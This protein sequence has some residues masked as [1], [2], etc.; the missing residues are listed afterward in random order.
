MANLK[1]QLLTRDRGKT[2]VVAPSRTMGRRAA[3]RQ[4]GLSHLSPGLI[5]T[6]MGRDAL[7]LASSYLNLGGEDCVLLPAYT[8][9]DVLKQFV[10]TATVLFYDVGPDLTISPDQILAHLLGRKVRMMLMINYFGFLQPYRRE[11]KDICA[12][13]GV[14][15][16]EDCAHS[17]LTEGSGETGDLAIYSFRKILP[18]PDGG[19]LKV[20][21]QGKEP[22]PRYYPRF[23]SDLLSVLATAKS[24]LHI[25]TATLSR[26]RVSAGADRVNVFRNT[27]SAVVE[28]KGRI[29][30][31]SFSTRVRLAH[32]PYVEVIR[33][34]RADFQFWRDIS[35]STPSIRPIFEDIPPGVCPL[36]FPVK[37]KDRVPLEQRAQSAG[38]KLAVHWR[39]NPE[40]APHC[41]TSH[42]LSAHML[43]LPLYPAIT[44]KERERLAPIV[45]GSA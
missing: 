44:E 30:P 34:R 38:I 17:L 9:Q 41:V 14:F 43:T 39:L 25:R 27:S 23:Y 22:A 37:I 26:A 3:A 1:P 19:A 31:L 32:L 35:L 16:I 29:L 33:R 6:F 36:G 10:N 20:N 15:L 13:R 4:S 21:C 8:C 5:G 40:L 12:D 42:E 2:T 18:V 24:A 28:A 7:S 11:I 45:A